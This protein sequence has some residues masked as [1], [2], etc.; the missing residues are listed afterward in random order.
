MGTETM[1]RLEW[2]V[3][4]L[5]IWTWV[6]LIGWMSKWW[7][8]SLLALTSEEPER[9]TGQEGRGKRIS[10]GERFRDYSYSNGTNVCM[11]RAP[12]IYATS[13]NNLAEKKERWTILGVYSVHCL[14][15]RRAR[16]SD[17]VSLFTLCYGQGH[18]VR[19]KATEQGRI[20]KRNGKIS[21][22]DLDRR[23]P[24]RVCTRKGK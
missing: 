6:L 21:N 8:A 19:L 4:H 10:S 20:G 15:S 9:G 23:R 2:S 12:I 13:R 18:K 24:R 1:G 22:G 11:R 3:A 17:V 5:R 16:G 14:R 7:W